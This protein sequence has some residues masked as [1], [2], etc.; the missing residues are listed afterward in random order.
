MPPWA[1]AGPALPLRQSV[2]PSAALGPRGFGVAVFVACLSLPPPLPPPPNTLNVHTHTHIHTLM[3][4]PVNS[5][6]VTIHILLHFGFPVSFMN[7][8]CVER[9]SFV[10]PLYSVECQAIKRPELRSRHLRRRWPPKW[11]CRPRYK[12]VEQGFVTVRATCI[13]LPCFVRPA[14]VTCNVVPSC[15]VGDTSC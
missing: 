6:F 14:Y 11:V 13:P 4:Q 8:V 12:A 10:L 7:K 5:Y 9:T 1:V 3:L 2:L 15:L